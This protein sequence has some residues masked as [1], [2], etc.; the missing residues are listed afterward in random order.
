MLLL[1]VPLPGKSKILP[2]S[3]CAATGHRQLYLPIKATWG[4]GPSVSYILTH[5]FPCNFGNQINIMQT[6]NQI[7]NITKRN[8]IMN[9]PKFCLLLSIAFPSLELYSFCP[10]KNVPWPIFLLTDVFITENV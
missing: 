7:H 4:Q 5:K 1:L 10:K 3:A 2:L 6:I 8:P 9:L